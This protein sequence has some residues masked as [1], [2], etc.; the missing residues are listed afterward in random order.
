MARDRLRHG[1]VCFWVNFLFM[2]WRWYSLELNIHQQILS[3]LA[4]SVVEPQDDTTY[5]QNLIGSR[6]RTRADS[7]EGAA[8]EDERKQK[9]FMV[10]NVCCF[11]SVP[12]LTNPACFSRPL[13][14]RFWRT[15]R[16]FP[17]VPHGKHDRHRYAYALGYPQRCTLYR[18]RQELILGR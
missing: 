17:W 2:D 7:N 14:Y 15:R 12:M 3:D 5:A 8:S 10:K 16:E 18:F 1:F 13:Q 11:M 6:V 4:S 9:V